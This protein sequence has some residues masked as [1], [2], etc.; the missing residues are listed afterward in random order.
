MSSVYQTKEWKEKAQAFVAEEK[1]VWCGTTENLVPHHPRR[2]GGYT[3]EEYLNVEEFCR[4]K[5]GKK[6]I[7]CSTCNFMESKSYKLC[8]KCKKHY[9]KPKRGR[10]MCWGCFT[11]TDP[12]GIK[13]KAYYD[14]HPEELKRRKRKF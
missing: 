12:V 2:R 8:P 11:T 1:C 3:R 9:Y 5:D 14:E 10:T 6:F 4:T 7:L 13:M